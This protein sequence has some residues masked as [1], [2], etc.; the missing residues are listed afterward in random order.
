MHACRGPMPATTITTAVVIPVVMMS[1]DLP[2]GVNRT[3]SD[4]RC[5]APG[6]KRENQQIYQTED[7]A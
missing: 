3:D 2:S 5:H 6:G 1:F 4:Q 7:E